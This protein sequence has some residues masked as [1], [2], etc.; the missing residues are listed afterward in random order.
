MNILYDHE[1]FW[2]QKYGG[3]S[4]Y[5]Y[6]IICRLAAHAGTDVSVFMGFHNN[7]YGLENYREQ[8][9]RFFGT[10]RPI[11]PKTTRL[12]SKLNDLMFLFFKE[13]TGFDIYHQTYYRKFLPGKGKKMI[14]TM[15][16]MIY[17][18][19]PQE[20]SPND[21]V[22]PLKKW[23]AEKADGIICV[24]ESTKRD[25]IRLFRIPEHKIKVIYHGNSLTNKVTTP[26]VVSEPYILYVGLRF[27][28]KNFKMLLDAYA[29]ANRVREDFRLVCFGGG[30]LKPGEEKFISELNLTNKVIHISG[31]DDVLANLYNYASVFVYPSL[32][33]GFGIPPLEA[34]HY[35]C[36]VLVSSTSSIPEVV[37]Q[38]G[39]YFDPLSLDE[40]VFKLEHVLY[41][42][43][44]KKQ[45]T[46]A[47]YEREKLFS[48]DKAAD[49]TLSFY[50]DIS[51]R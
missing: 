1:I 3:I 9:Y 19:F 46:K 8:Y 16:D 15:H 25:L 22:P 27:G 24:S 50:K 48:W 40:L 12:F 7:G 35:G 36:P 29:K 26:A 18:L 47:G 4:R 30:P 21:P 41:D 44:L 34:M 6:E 14:I 20:F 11:I 33:E 13:T 38:A 23:T 45:L 5:F 28:Y 17:E 42:D 32:Y 37:G 39:L 10:A 31:S 2:L 51:I 49:E 43:S